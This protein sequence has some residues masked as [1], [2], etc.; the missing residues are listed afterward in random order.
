[1][2]SSGPGQ[3]ITNSR[4]IAPEGPNETAHRFNICR[5]EVPAPPGFIFD[6]F[7]NLF[8]CYLFPSG[9]V[10]LLLVIPCPVLGCAMTGAFKVW[11]ALCI[12]VAVSPLRG[13]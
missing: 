7:W 13:L 3:G 6:I 4:E 5:K 12:Q 8:L 1:M 10:S 9:L 11:H 2:D